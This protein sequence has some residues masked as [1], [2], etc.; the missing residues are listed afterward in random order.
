MQNGGISTMPTVVKQ[1]G[2]MGKKPPV[3]LLMDWK[4]LHGAKLCIYACGDIKKKN[5]RACSIFQAASTRQ[6]LDGEG[7]WGD[8]LIPTIHTARTQANNIASPLLLTDYCWDLP[9]YSGSAGSAANGGNTCT[10]AGR[11]A[12]SLLGPERIC[13]VPLPVCS[14]AISPAFALLRT[15]RI[16]LFFFFT[17]RFR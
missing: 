11:L 4:T 17:S 1:T 14:P 10:R 2:S 13:F 15:E 16:Y 6:N 8:N 5:P 9:S 12:V 7:T 3:L